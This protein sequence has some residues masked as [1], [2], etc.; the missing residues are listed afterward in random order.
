MA[1]AL[2]QGGQY[3]VRILTR[4]ADSEKAKALQAA[5]AEVVVGDLSNKDSL[6]AAVDG[7][8]GVFGVTNFWEHFGK[9]YEQGVNLID[10]VAEGGVQ[11][12]VLHTLPDYNALS[13]GQYSVP[14]CDM[15]AALKR[16]T[17]QKNLPATFLEV[18]FY[19]E[20]S[21]FSR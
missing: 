3:A 1:K 15:K 12:F 20:N 16:Y 4:K 5:G 10:A 14:H 2:L 18:A 19:Y 13:S 6:K 9:E 21:L 8:Y 17:K 7:C 11:H